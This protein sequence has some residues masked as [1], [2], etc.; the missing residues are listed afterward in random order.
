MN[1]TK[2]NVDALNAV[3]TVELAKADFEGNVENVLKNYRKTANVPGFRKGQVPMS[4]VKKQYGMAVLFDEVNKLLQDNLNTYINEEKL[5]IL[6]NPIPV[7]KDVDWDADV[8]SFDF[9]LGLAPEFAVELENVKDVKKFNIVA[10]ETSIDEQVEYIQKQY[11]KINKKEEVAEEDTLRVKVTNE[12]EGIDNESS[13]ELSEIR[14]KTNQKKFIGKKVGDVVT[15]STKGL[16]EDEHRLMDV[17]KVDHDKVHGLDVEVAFEIKD[18]FNQE[19]AELNQELYH[20]LFGEGKVSSEEELRAKIKEEA[21]KQFVSQADNQFTSAVVDYLVENTKFELPKEFLV[22]WLQTVSEKPLTAEEA[23]EEYNK[24]EKGLRYQLI[25]GKL[26]TGN[27][28]QNTFEDIKGYAS[29]LI[30][31]QMAMFGQAEPTEDQVENIV[32]R[33]LSN[34]DEVKRISEQLI[35]EKLLKLFSEKVPST[36]KEVTYKEFVKEVYGE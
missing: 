32:A 17:L 23:E 33:V 26:I 27:Q 12:A 22:K 28:L 2:K 36:A 21:E 11:G 5:E 20:K 7:V 24:S 1:I 3:V 29:N 34:Q 35:N 4:L 8:L 16:F 6:G 18:V 30:K 14:T 31:E 9:E 25:E 19:K 10:D 13:F 15:L